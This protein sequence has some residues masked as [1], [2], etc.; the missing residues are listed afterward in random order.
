MSVWFAGAGAAQ[1]PDSCPDA[2]PSRLVVGEVGR[3]TPGEA[4]NV[5]AEPSADGEL[6]GQITGD[7]LFS[8][9]EGPYC[10]DGFA[11][12]HVATADLDGWT[13]EGGAEYWLEPVEGVTYADGT[14][15][16]VYPDKVAL[17]V[18]REVLEPGFTVMGDFPTRLRYDITLPD[19]IFL[20]ITLM[21]TAAVT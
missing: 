16:L 18:E 10:A 14:L 5:R 4:N 12:W 3:V 13:V 15:W 1:S 21:E 2:L 11:W 17:E 9:V 19:E 20:R 8:V 6:V 7:S